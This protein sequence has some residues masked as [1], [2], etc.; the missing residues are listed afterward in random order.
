MGDGGRS[1]FCEGERAGQ[2]V[3]QLESA[4]VGV[5]LLEQAM[6]K[7]FDARCLELCSL[8][9]ARHVHD[10]LQERIAAAGSQGDVTM[11]LEIEDHLNQGCYYLAV[12]GDWPRMISAPQSCHKYQ[13]P[14]A[15]DGICRGYQ[16][17]QGLLLESAKRSG[18]VWGEVWLTKRC[19]FKNA[20][21]NCFI[22]RVRF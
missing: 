5:M 15:H 4:H 22:F 16:C 20:G 3:L 17:T 11:P 13:S 10:R 19:G 14:L 2:E 18:V 21:V 12:H 9:E 7:S 1:Q 6:E 8:S